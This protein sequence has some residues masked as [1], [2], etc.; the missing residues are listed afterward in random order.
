MSGPS[1]SVTS[2]DDPEGDFAGNVICIETSMGLGCD[3]S[4]LTENCHHIRSFGGA[5]AQ[6]VDL[7]G[8]GS[9]KVQQIGAGRQQS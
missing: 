1:T 9:R 4:H 3:A 7:A 2:A 5:A 6:F 8:H